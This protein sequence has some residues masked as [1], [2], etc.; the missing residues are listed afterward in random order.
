MEWMVILLLLVIIIMIAVKH[1]S[2][3]EMMDGLH[4]EIN[5]LQE[6]VKLLKAGPPKPA[7][8]AL[9]AEAAVLPPKKQSADL[10]GAELQAVIRPVPSQ[11]RETE[12]LVTP[13]PQP[14]QPAQ[15]PAE[16][17]IREP[18]EA[19]PEESRPAPGFF[20]RHPDLEKF[21][22]EN[23]VS[24]IGIAILVLA[25][26]FFVK[27]AIDNNWIGPVGRVAIGMLCGGI[28]TAVAHLLHK[29]YKAFSSILVGGGLAV[30]YFT[31]ALAFHQY[32]L[33]SQTTAFV[34]MVVIT[35]FAVGMSLLYNRQ[36]LAI[37]SMVGG[38][39]T[40]FMVSN[41][42]H[43]YKA[44]F[45]YLIILNT[46]LL[47]L[48]YRKAWRLLNLLAFLFT[49]L[50]F[51]SW[52]FSLPT[53][54]PPATYGNG[55]LFGTVFYLLFFA[56]NIAYNIRENRAFLASDFGILLANTCLYFSTGILMLKTWHQEPYQGLFCASIGV[57]NL[58]MSY[59]LMRRKKADL[60]IIYLLIGITL[61][62]ISLSAPIQLHGNYITLFWASECVLLYWLFQKSGIRLI[63]LASLL[64]WVAMLF[65]LAGDWIQ[66]YGFSRTGLPVMANRGFITS[67][68]AA[69]SCYALMLLKSRDRPG[70]VR[71]PLGVSGKGLFLAGSILLFF[72]GALEIDLQFSTRFPD[73]S[74]SLLYLQLYVYTFGLVFTL[75]AGSARMQRVA[76]ASLLFGCLLVY[77]L[78]LVPLMDLQQ[79]MLEKNQLLSHF[80]AHWVADLVL[81]L[82]IYRLFGWL[83]V[84]WTGGLRSLPM[85]TVVLSAFCVLW[86]S[87]ELYLVFNGHYHSKA[88]PT[89]EIQRVY[90]KSGLPILWGLCSFCLMWLG[91][92]FK[93]KTLRISGLTLFLITL[94]KLFLF[95]IRNIPVTGKISAFFCLG[96]L[97]LVVSF[98]YQRLKKIIIEDEN[99]KSQ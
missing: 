82:L 93:F 59:L 29:N 32:Q 5:L 26:G 30:F 75:A 1:R 14:K 71:P 69:F 40:P 92:H 49:S 31:I 64:V 42:S 36:E 23:I 90:I 72:S 70:G 27:F 58:M 76:G 61:T 83:N 37:I 68:Y 22:G 33:F 96:I 9:P 18:R 56:I 34:I 98:M 77:L 19:A 74:L 81:A 8:P 39:F 52:L 43:H 6:Q 3:T 63:G 41:G 95:D 47:V 4:R 80:A 94:L 89:P 48:A 88:Y 51:C 7:P 46:G 79:D 73:T 11:P 53:S 57:F 91:M 62:F 45:I 65:S 13:L 67:L 20:E 86:L 12:P 55:L 60:H 97:L 66:L 78:T 25:I 21:I 99:K 17:K 28:L 10:A 15:Q 54:E 35:V 87:V 38:F 44:L 2:L 85:L 84:K 24:K 50:L 16:E